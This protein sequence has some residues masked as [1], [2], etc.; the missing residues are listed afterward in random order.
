MTPE[1][2]RRDI[3]QVVA[4]ALEEDVGSGDL[5]A[6][7]VPEEARCEATVICREPAVICGKA[8]FTEVFRQVDSAVAIHWHVDDGE[9]ASVNQ[10]LCLV[11]GAARSMLTA[12]RCALNFLQTLSGT[13]TL[14][15]RYADVVR[16]LPVK[17]LDTRKTVPGLRLAQKYAVTR[18]GCYN[19]RY[20]LSDGVLIKENHIMAAGSISQAVVA[21]R[22]IA[23]SVPVEVE[24][25]NLAEVRE[26]LNAG[27]DIVLLDN[28]DVENLRNAVALCAGRAKLEA[29]GGVSMDTVRVIAKT[30]VDYISIGALTK[31]VKAVD[32]SMRFLPIAV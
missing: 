19:H 11:V 26:A 7:L 14:A 4:H 22:E 6:S 23:G 29:S 3:E 30:G 16:G 9:E 5:T 21:A 28:F 27:A 17:L 1:A 32:L 12:E 15:K 13:A 18:G 2:L 20:G 31:D 25:E 10:E 24:V 8:W